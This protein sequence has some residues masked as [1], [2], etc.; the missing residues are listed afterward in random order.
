MSVTITID[1]LPVELRVTHY[2]PPAPP[3]GLYGQGSAAEVEWIGPDWL[4]AVADHFNLWDAIDEL[5][6]DAIADRRKQEG[7]DTP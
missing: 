6:L 5:V 4:L 7:G 3:R 1:N 2:Q